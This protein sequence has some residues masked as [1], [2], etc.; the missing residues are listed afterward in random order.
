MF[1][2]PSGDV[3]FVLLGSKPVAQVRLKKKKS[4]FPLFCWF[5]NYVISFLMFVND[6]NKGLISHYLMKGHH[7]SFL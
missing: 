1:D 4:L 7:F 2:S 3:N 6:G 5:L